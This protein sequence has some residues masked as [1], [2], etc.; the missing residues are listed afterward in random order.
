MEPH[1][2]NAELMGFNGNYTHHMD[3]LVLG[4]RKMLSGFSF[5]VRPVQGMLWDLVLKSVNRSLNDMQSIMA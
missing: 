3:P 2:F 1:P 5:S 4:S